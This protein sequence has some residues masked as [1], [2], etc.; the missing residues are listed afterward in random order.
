MKN[1]KTL[2]LGSL[3]VVLAIFLAA[4]LWFKKTETTKQMETASK[5]QSSL[6]RGYSITLGPDDAKVTLVEFLDPECESCRAFYPFVK[7]L[8]AKHPNDIRLVVRYAPFHPNSRF[9]IKILEA[10]RLQNRYWD[11]LSTLFYYQ[12]NWGDHHNPKP[13]L[14]WNYLPETGVDIDQIRKDLENPN[15]AMIIEQDI[16]DSKDLGVRATPSFFING[17]PLTEFGFNQLQSAIEDAL[18][19]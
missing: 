3:T 4:T 17:K 14:I 9:A 5:Q 10:A 15:T 19:Q 6:Q 16:M 7:N 13:E 1:K 12:P 8:M 11:V 18:A 2:L